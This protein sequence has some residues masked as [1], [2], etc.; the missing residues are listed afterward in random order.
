MD[1]I[2]LSTPV[3]VKVCRRTPAC[4]HNHYYPWPKKSPQLFHDCHLLSGN[5]S[6][7]Y[8]L[9]QALGTLTDLEGSPICGDKGN[10]SGQEM[11]Q[12]SYMTVVQWQLRRHA[13]QDTFDFGCQFC[14]V[15]I[16]SYSVLLNNVVSHFSIFV[17][18]LLN[19]Y[20]VF[21]APIPLTPNLGDCLK[22]ISRCHS[23][24]HD[25]IM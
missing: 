18:Q 25:T 12:E 24:L 4:W 19:L 20:C 22:G 13:L 21:K 23:M 16:T 6:K 1:I 15:M 5:R 17:I 8:S 11:L 9:Y 14:T 2:N 3:C 10:K 7:S